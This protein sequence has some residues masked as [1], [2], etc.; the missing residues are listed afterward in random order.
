V[1]TVIFDWEGTL[2]SGR[3][4]PPG[5][6]AAAVASLLREAGIDVSGARL[7]AALARAGAVPG[8]AGS[9]ATLL[10]DA[11]DLLGERVTANL[12]AECSM[13]AAEALMA[14]LSVYQDARALLPSLRYRGYSV[15]IVA[16]SAFSGA[17]IRAAAGRL[18]LAGYLDAVVTSADAGRAKP[19]PVPYRIAMDA[20]G[21]S[22]DDVL[23]VGDRRETDIAGAHAAGLRAALLDRRN[24]GL[25]EPAVPVVRHLGE[26][27]G[28]L[29]E[30]IVAR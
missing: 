4:P 17:D 10:R 2:V 23:C 29:G 26:L 1:R 30:G 16:N 5:T 3:R 14:G 9:L 25:A 13:R 27:N 19:D 11:F 20:L 6:L 22:P 12:A 8:P 7:D 21:C 15:A 28:L 24:R 18:G